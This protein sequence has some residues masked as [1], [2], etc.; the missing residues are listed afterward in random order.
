MAHAQQIPVLTVCEVLH[1]LPKYNGKLVIVVGRVFFTF[2]G[3]FMNEDCGPGGTT[4]VQGKRW[5]SMIA[6][7]SPETGGPVVVRW[8]HDVLSQKLNQVQ[9]TTHLESPSS[10]PL[11]DRWSAVCGRLEAPQKLR[12]PNRSKSHPGNGYGAN[13]SVPAALHKV[14]DYNF[15]N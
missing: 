15:P 9:Q 3:T 5:L 7:G 8:D 6:F 2:E 13:G 10:S 14:Q 1:E 12:P 11:G 4:T